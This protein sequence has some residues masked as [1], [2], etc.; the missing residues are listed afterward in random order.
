VALI[1]LAL[2]VKGL[3]GLAGLAARPD[4]RR[5]GAFLALASG[6]LLINFPELLDA[7]SQTI[8]GRDSADALSYRPPANPAAGYL[9][10]VFLVV[11]IVG[12]VGVARGVY[13]LRL[14]GGE[15]GGLPRALVHM[16]GGILCLNL[17]EFLRLLAASVGGE[18]EALVSAIIG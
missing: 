7:L 18:V 6:I 15:G 16:V 11:A 1:G 13:I 9:R 4:G 2:V 8:L 14:T 17:P 3:A 12:L 5:L 10:L